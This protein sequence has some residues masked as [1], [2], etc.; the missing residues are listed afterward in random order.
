MRAQAVDKRPEKTVHDGQNKRVRGAVCLFHPVFLA[1]RARFV[2]GVPGRQAVGVGDV[3]GMSRANRAK[4]AKPER[5]QSGVSSFCGEWY[6][7]SL[8]SCVALGARSFNLPLIFM[9]AAGRT[10]GRPP[11]LS[12]NGP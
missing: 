9:P 11:A 7:W 2:P 4:T 10:P 5:S 6:A 8:N 3:A 1:R 12:R